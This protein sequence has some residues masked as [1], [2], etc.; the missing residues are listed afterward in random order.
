MSATL[1]RSALGSAQGD[2]PARDGGVP[3]LALAGIGGALVVAMILAAIGGS[4]TKMAPSSVLAS[5]L[6]RF[7]DAS[8]GAVV[9][10]DANT[11][12]Q[13]GILAPGTNG[14][15]RATLRGLS[16]SQGHEQHPRANHPFLLT[17]RSDGRVTLYDPA[18]QRTLDLEAFGS[19]NAGAYV[20]LLTAPEKPLQ[21]PTQ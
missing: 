9:V 16:H 20:A 1:N 15:I 18:T 11:N 3:F 8:N 19:L 4:P 12:R 21:E 6:L 13:V 2:T 10:T 17:A 7:D 14:F 5:R